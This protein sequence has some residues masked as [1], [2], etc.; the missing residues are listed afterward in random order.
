M[1]QTSVSKFSLGGGYCLGSGGTDILNED[2]ND[3]HNKD[4]SG[5]LSDLIKYKSSFKSSTME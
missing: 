2:Q 4:Q 5:R 3:I 1:V